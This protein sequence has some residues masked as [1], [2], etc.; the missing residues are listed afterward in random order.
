M[1]FFIKFTILVGNVLVGDVQKCLKKTRPRTCP[2]HVRDT[3]GTRPGHWF[4][5]RVLR[6]DTGQGHG[7]G[8]D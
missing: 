5:R 3:S 8:Q 6:E 2:G 4:T 1:T 7:H